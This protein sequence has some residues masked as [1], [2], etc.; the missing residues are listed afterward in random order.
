MYKKLKDLYLNN[1]YNGLFAMAVGH[2]LTIGFID[3]QEITDEQ[4]ET[5]KGNGLMTAAFCQDL[6][7]LTRE[8]A[9]TCENNPVELI[10]FCMVEDIFDT[11]WYKIENGLE[12]EEEDE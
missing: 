1:Q 12:E 5:V 9:L 7:R 10:Q 4:I 11:H 2:L 6:I 3:A 8:I